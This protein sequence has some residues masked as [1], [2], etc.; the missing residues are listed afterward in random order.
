MSATIRVL[1]VD[2]SVVFR[3]AISEALTGVDGIEVVGSAPN[4]RIA[5]AKLDALQPDVVTLDVDMPEM[6]GLQTLDAIRRQRP[7]T[8]VI[9]CS[10]ASDEDSRTTLS[11][12]ERGA[13]DFVSKPTADNPVEA[14]AALA[15][16]LVPRIRALGRRTAPG[17]TGVRPAVRTPPR[18]MPPGS[19]AHA[20]APPR[21]ASAAPVAPASGPNPTVAPPRGPAG[22]VDLLA[23]GCST[24]G[25][26]AL[27][28]LV[29]RLPLKL[30]V[31]VVIVQ[32]MPPMFTRLLA[33]R[34][35]AKSGLPVREA[36]GGEP[37]HA[38]ELWIA[39]GG[40]HLV[41]LRDGDGLRLHL[42]QDPPENSCR[43]AVDPLFRSCAAARGAAVLAVVLTGMGEDGMR[44]AQAVCAAGGRVLAQDKA[45]SVVWGMPGAV[46]RAGLAEKLLPIEGMADEIVVRLRTGRPLWLGAARARNAP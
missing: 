45:T 10:S 24:G 29:P 35:A 15:R 5:L 30:P 17:D 21:P 38:G 40:S 23:I 16:E 39:P 25:P 4:G 43:P 7:G 32:H 33:E 1:V 27:D 26:N 3:R 19:G 46:A 36:A 28:E 8:A 31:P 11:A 41:V 2:D 22:R 42:N 20:I 14:R 18:P 34:L 9:M 13:G 6:D 37:L 12:L 44:G